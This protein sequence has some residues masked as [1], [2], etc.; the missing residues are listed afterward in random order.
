MAWSTCWFVCGFL[1]QE[2]DLRELFSFDKLRESGRVSVITTEEF[3]EKEALSGN[4]GISPSENVKRL[5]NKVRRA[6]I[7]RSKTFKPG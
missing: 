5:N 3:I 7:G 1:L 6:V 2:V 4:L